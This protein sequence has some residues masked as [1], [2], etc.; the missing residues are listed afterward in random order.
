MLLAIGAGGAA[1]AGGAADVDNGAVY[2]MTNSPSGNAVVVF[3]RAADGTLTKTG[4]FP[5]GGKSIG[6]FATGNQNG[7]LLS[8]NGHCLWAVNS[9][10]NQISAFEAK[11]TS[12]RFINIVNSNGERPISLAVNEALGVLYVLNAGGQ[13]GST[14]NITGFTLDRDCALSALAGST[15]VLSGKNVSPAEVGF[16]PSGTVLVV[17][18]KTNDSQVGSPT[19]PPVTP[20]VPPVKGGNIDTF[21]VGHNGLL[22]SGKHFPQPCGPGNMK[23]PVTEPFGFAFDNRG[24]LLVTAADC[25]HPEPP[26]GGLPGCTVPK[27]HPSVLSYILARDGTLKLVDAFANDQAA[28]C[29]IVIANNQKFVFT[30]NA[31]ATHPGGKPGMLPAGSITGYHLSPDGDLSKLGVTLVPLNPLGVPVDAALSLNSR[32]LYVLSEGDGNIDAYKVGHDGGLTPLGTFA[33]ENT[34]PNGPFP[35]GLAAR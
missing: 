15:R 27:D 8:N 32:F 17:T 30:I 2:A 33:I 3:D 16:D 4:T 21:I 31:L 24:Q 34:L 6:I 26:F 29:W 1:A 35:N 28:T 23:C 12:L 22:S 14:D 25:T 10:S 7:L 18:E 11:G 19:V 9:A 5:T 13:V 20:P